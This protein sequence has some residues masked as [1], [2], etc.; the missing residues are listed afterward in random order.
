[1]A[2]FAV[3]CPEASGHLNPM[4]T[5]LAELQ[6]RGHEITWIGSL[7][8]VELASRRG[9]KTVTIAEDRI[10]AGTLD[11]RLA[12][13]GKLSGLAAARRTIEFY[14]EGMEIILD[15]A[16]QAIRA[17]GA[18]ALIMDESIFAARTVAE[19]AQLPW[20]T[21]C[22]ALPFHPDPD[23]P[24]LYPAWPYRAGWWARIRNRLGHLPA[25]ILLRP[26]ARVILDARTKHGLDQYNL[27][28]EN[29]SELVTI[30]QIPAEFDYPRRR[31]PDWF[32]YVGALHS[33]DTRPSIDF[34]YDRL[35]D[36]PLIYA[37]LGTVQN[38][39]LPVFE[40]I[41]KACATLP[42]QL[43][44]S[45]GGGATPNALG[46]LAGD[47]LVVQFAPQLELIKRARLVITHAGMNTT[48]ESLAAGVPMVAIPITNDQPAVAARIAWTGSGVNV[49]LWRAT[50]A[51]I[52]NAV[53]RV[54]N[55][56]TYH[57]AAQRLSEANR[58]AGGA[59]RAAD[60][61]CGQVPQRL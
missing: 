37:S 39:V 22:N 20:V 14:R 24:P 3:L 47:P 42:A 35:D 12:E 56:S 36:R 1:M 32:H 44:I 16:P 51:R 4:S 49:P 23:H 34:P 11:E 59:P 13:V 55:T 40:S 57:E 19:L 48:M 27:A 25:A 7:D 61:I 33:T 26:I 52:G 9:F 58:H 41:A 43:V 2:H 10:P 21:I 29:P 6:C 15:D 50:T 60:I 5:L 28:N 46:R 53:N 54:L 8:G 30:A 18:T 17:C 45:L 31:Q 38:R